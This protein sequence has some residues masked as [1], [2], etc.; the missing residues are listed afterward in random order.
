MA[1]RPGGVD[2]EGGRG[3][4]AGMCRAEQHHFATFRTPL[5]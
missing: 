2:G 3:D 5:Q 4:G 1:R